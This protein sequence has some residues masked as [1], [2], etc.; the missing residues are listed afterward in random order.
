MNESEETVSDNEILAIVNHLRAQ[1]KDDASY[2]AKACAAKLSKDIW[3]T[4]VAFANTAGGTLILG[5]SETEGFTPVPNFDINKVRDQFLSGMGDGGSRGRLTNPPHYEITRVEFEGSPLLIIGIDELDSSHKPCYITTRGVQGGSYKRVDDADIPLSANEIYSLDTANVVTDSDRSVVPDASVSDLDEYLLSQTF[6]TARRM[7]PR[8]LRG[9]DT[10]EAKMIRLN[11]T[12]REKKVTKAGLLTTGI[13]P[14]QYFP[15]L[16][17][18]V[19]VYPGIQKGAPDG[20]RFIDRVICEGTLGEM[21]EG[22]VAAIAKNLRQTSVVNGVGRTDELE[23]PEEVLREAIANA[24]IHRDYDA[25]FDGQAISVDVFDDRIEVINPGGLWG[26]KSRDNLADGRS[27]CRNATLMRLMSL[28]PLPNGAGS[29]AEGN[30]SGIPLMMS[31]SAAHGLEPP[32]FCPAIDHFKVVMYRPVAAHRRTILPTNNE[33]VI[34]SLLMKYGEMSV[35][36]LEEKSGL[37]I[38]QVRNRIRK[39]LKNGSIE[40]TAPPTSH[41]RKYR[42]EQ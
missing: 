41:S 34:Q 30:G 23:I 33:Q 1:G 5:L 26:G 35:R 36:E 38:N 29:P 21:I 42:I 13:Y 15:K 19:A 18:D 10:P 17:I 8:A 16:F 11:L 22:A 12:I 37:N 27:C 24:T 2:E 7:T 39:L 4:V 3:E 40:A 20:P 25:R 31:E 9:A 14:Q 32:I 28:V 6:A